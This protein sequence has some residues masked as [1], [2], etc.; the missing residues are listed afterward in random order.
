MAH[1]RTIMERAYT[2]HIIIPS[3]NI[4]HLPMMAPV[5][6][7]L[8]EANAF[9]L[10]AVARLEWEKFQSKSLEAIALEYE[11]QGDAHVTS[12]HLDHIPVV[13]ED[14]L[15]VDYMDYIRK[16]IDVG[17]KSVM[18]DGSRLGLKENIICVKEVVDY[19]HAHDIPVE[20]E[21]GAVIQ[22]L[23]NS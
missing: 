5:V 16:A 6:R 10:I 8:K 22:F 20:A 7:A 11:K 13:D 9:G 21:L 15:R 1:I 12:L 4:P 3:F 2:N 23:L 14:H 18:V 17:Y 19:A